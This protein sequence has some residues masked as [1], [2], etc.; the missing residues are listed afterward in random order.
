MG[1]ISGVAAGVF[2]GE[3]CAPAKIVGDAFVGLL[4]MTVMPYLIVS[5]VANLGRLSPYQ[6][7][8]LALIGGTVLFGLWAIALICVF[9]LANAFP[10]FKGGSFFSSSIVEQSSDTDLVSIFIP[11]NIFESLAR[12]HVP[13]VVLL[14]IFVGLALSGMPQRQPLIEQLD[15]LS[16][17]LI[18]VTKTIAK[19]TPIGVFAI[20]AS[21]TGS[22]SLAEVGRLHTYLIAY[23]CGALF[24][25]LVALPLLVSSF[26]P[27][28]YS[29]VISVS[30]NAMLTAFATGKLI[31]VLPILIEETERLFERFRDEDAADAAPAVD[32]LYPVAYPF[33]HVGKLLSMLFV[34]FAAWF[35]G[36]ALS[37][38]DFPAFLVAGLFSYFGGPNLAMPF[39]LDLMQLPHDMFQ[40]F[41]LTGVY[42]S[43]VGDALGALH[44]A[45][46]TILATCAFLG[47]LELN[48]SNWLRYLAIVGLTGLSMIIVLKLTL[49]NTLGLVADREEVIAS[50]QLLDEPVD[51]VVFT[52]ATPNPEPLEAGESLLQRIRRRQVIRVGYNE[53]KLPFA[54]TNIEGQLVGFDIDMAHALAKDLGVSIEFVRFDRDTLADQLAQDDFD[55]VM[56]GLVGTLERA[57]KMQHTEPY[58]HV[59]L[60][61]VVPD[62]R[63]RDFKTLASLQA[64]SNLKIAFVDLSRGF[65][66]R[67]QSDLPNA[68]FIELSTSQEYFEKEWENVDAF[69]IS[70]ESGSAFSL[71]YPGFEVVV[72]EGLRAE[73]PLFYAI[74]ARDTEMRDF[75]E[76][77]VRLRKGDGTTQDY[78][79]HWILGKKR[80]GTEP[81]WSIIRN[82]LHWID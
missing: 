29:D 2:F 82:V 68:E 20:A 25:G 8:R 45:V 73:L 7:R 18:R 24:I 27:L 54:Y 51:S 72:P 71:F 66:R 38:Q 74:G 40:L 43:R 69:L 64:K 10:E 79:D 26:T 36:S 52:E 62:F 9:G 60:G 65:V 55:V 39:L 57:E 28:R 59:T 23:T 6:S 16:K 50:M 81:R 32:V 48:V 35:L 56:S 76:H 63:G 37:L 21:T 12:N 14:C 17:V 13:A 58:M 22:I 41:L 61:L 46:F 1:L 77:W 5:L 78:Y 42:E 34:P 11:S 53:D 70:A 30:R 49:G 75:L 80:K 19:L 4:R 47:K 44:L 33:P 3:L 31:I 15:L 67:L